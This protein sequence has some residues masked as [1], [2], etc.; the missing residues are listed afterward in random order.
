MG[1]Q[2]SDPPPGAPVLP[3]PQNAFAIAFSLGLVL[4]CGANI[5]DGFG[6]PRF[7]SAALALP[8]GVLYSACGA[9]LL[10]G[11]HGLVASLAQRRS[12]GYLWALAGRPV[13]A[14]GAGLLLLGFGVLLIVISVRDL[15]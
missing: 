5:F 15:V 4:I 3:D 12:E 13:I 10:T 6:A 11:W 7:V 2:T 8:A 14:R 9:M 1:T